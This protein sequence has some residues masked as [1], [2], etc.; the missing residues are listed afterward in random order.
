MGLGRRSRMEYST[1]CA[2]AAEVVG[3]PGHFYDNI[4]FDSPCQF[5]SYCKACAEKD[6][7]ACVESREGR[8]RKCAQ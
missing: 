8:R 1:T 5:F 4:H 6:D 2:T 3:R 7:E